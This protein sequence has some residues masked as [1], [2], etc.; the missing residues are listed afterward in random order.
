M[1][2]MPANISDKLLTAVAPVSI[3]ILTSVVQ[4]GVSYAWYRVIKVS[5]AKLAVIM[6]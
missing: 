2:L 1:W 6:S 5:I 4:M 3:N